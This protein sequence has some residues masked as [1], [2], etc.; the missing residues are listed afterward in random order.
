MRGFEAR[1][2]AHFDAF[3]RYDSGAVAKDP[4]ELLK[5]I[6]VSQETL[7]SVRLR[8]VVGKAT[9]ALISIAALLAVVASRLSIAWMLLAVAILGVAIFV[10]FLFRILSFADKHPDL[11]LL[12]GAELVQWKQMDVA[13]KGVGNLPGGPLIETPPPIDTPLLGPKANT[14]DNE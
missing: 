8:G 13:A 11:A 14:P 10:F 2:D 1:F 9:L 12:E 7:E 4:L 3:G 6:G 5:E